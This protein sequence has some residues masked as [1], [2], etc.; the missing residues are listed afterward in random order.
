MLP[1]MPFDIGAMPNKRNTGEMP[2]MPID[3]NTTLRI[4]NPKIAH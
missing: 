3:S 1:L 4:G 2:H